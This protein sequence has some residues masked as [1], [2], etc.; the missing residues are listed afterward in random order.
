[1]IVELKGTVKRIE[2]TNRVSDKFQKRTVVITV[3]DGDYPQD[4]GVEFINDRVTVLD[5]YSEGQAVV[6]TANIAGRDWTNQEGVTR[7]FV[8]FKGWKIE[9]SEE[10]QQMTP[11]EVV[12]N[13]HALTDADDDLPF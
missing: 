3:P 1:M 2:D 9:A 13:A 6:C 12:E 10:G 8:S 7:N 5:N 4:I 11:K